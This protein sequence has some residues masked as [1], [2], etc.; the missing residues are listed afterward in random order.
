M[1]EKTLLVQQDFD[2]IAPFDSGEGWS[3]N[4]YY[5]PYLLKHLPAHCGSVCEIGCGTGGLA[6]TLAGRADSVLAL[7]LSPA[8]IRIAQERIVERFNERERYAAVL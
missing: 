4:Q 6:R 1:D 7:D 5:T 8:M 3:H 2:R